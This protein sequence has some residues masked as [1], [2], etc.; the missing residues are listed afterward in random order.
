VVELYI[1]SV[2]ICFLVTKRD[3]D[4]FR[5]KLYITSVHIFFPGFKINFFYISIFLKIYI[6][7]RVFFLKK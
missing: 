4:K 2:H 6:I 7:I 3:V 1:T 5:T